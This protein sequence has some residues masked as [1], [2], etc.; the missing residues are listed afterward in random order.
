MMSPKH[1]NEIGIVMIAGAAFLAAGCADAESDGTVVVPPA[2]GHAAR[3]QV[4]Y[5]FMKAS[6]RTKG[7][8]SNA[9]VSRI[10]NMRRPR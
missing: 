1:V 6:A 2:A 7:G 4:M 9:R 10:P 5:D 3:N 8:P